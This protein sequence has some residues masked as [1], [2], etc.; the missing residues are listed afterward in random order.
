[1]VQLPIRATRQPAAV[2]PLRLAPAQEA[3]ARGQESPTP[4][5]R[6]VQQVLFPE[7]LRSLLV[8][9]LSPEKLPFQLALEAAV[10]PLRAGAVVPPESSPSLLPFAPI[11]FPEGS[12][13]LHAQSP[14]IDSWADKSR[15]RPRNSCR[16]AP[17]E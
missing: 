12:L 2:F 3:L 6:W 13:P 7:L 9:P 16:L 15:A 4:A 8:L 14:P 17:L 10:L 5:P 11:G 1:P